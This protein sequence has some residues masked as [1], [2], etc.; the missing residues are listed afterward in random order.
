MEKDNKNLI[1]DYSVSMPLIV[2]ELSISE[3]K[4]AVEIPSTINSNELGMVSNGK[5]FVLPKWANELKIK[6]N[7]KD[8]IA[9]LIIKD[10]DD[11]DFLEQ[12]KFYSILKY[13]SINGFK[14][15]E[16]VRIILTAKTGGFAKISKRIQ[17]LCMVL[18]A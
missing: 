5:E 12:D 18:R 10:I 14:F 9:Y 6:A 15:P 7:E 1:L 3:I 4:N 13:S 8:D 17:A 2:E 16:N 11:I